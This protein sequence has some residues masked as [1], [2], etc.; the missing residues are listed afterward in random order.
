M[1]ISIYKKRHKNRYI[2]LHVFKMTVDTLNRLKKEMSNN[3]N[4]CCKNRFKSIKTELSETEVDIE[5]LEEI[6]E[7]MNITS[8]ETVV[9][10][11][12]LEETIYINYL[13]K[14]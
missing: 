7:H 2:E 6:L 8:S 9:T 3:K 13:E 14:N 10:D 12:E 5:H 1:C 11:T 4:F